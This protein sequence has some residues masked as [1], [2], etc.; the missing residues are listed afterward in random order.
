MRCLTLVL[1]AVSSPFLCLAQDSPQY[2][3]CDE[4]AK[5][6]L[7]MNICAF[8]EA[9]HGGRLLPPGLRASQMPD[10]PTHQIAPRLDRT[11]TNL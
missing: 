9:G 1:F 3:A 6:Q 8:E 10:S 11:P 4:K 5:T 7:E 2:H